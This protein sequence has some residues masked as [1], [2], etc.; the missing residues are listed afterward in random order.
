MRHKNTAAS[1][2]VYPCTKLQC[3]IFV[4]KLQIQFSKY[5]V[6]ISS[7]IDNTHDKNNFFLTVGKIIENIIAD[8]LFS[9]TH[10]RQ[11]II[12]YDS[13]A[14]RKYLRLMYNILQFIQKS[15][16]SLGIG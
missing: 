6:H 13:A 7:T 15:S 16:R 4:V 10:I 14:L 9:K 8:Q 12:G 3:F 5:L 2:T 1:G 11:K